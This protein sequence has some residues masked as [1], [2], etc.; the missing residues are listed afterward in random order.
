MRGGVSTGAG[1]PAPLGAT[2]TTAGVNFALRSPSSTAA[3]IVVFDLEGG[4]RY[5]LELSRSAH[6]TGDVWHI[7]LTGLEPPCGYGW[8]LDGPFGDTDRFDPARLLLD[9]YAR[10]LGGSERWGRPPER[11]FS[12]VTR[13]S[14]P[15]GSRPRPAVEPAERVIY[16]LS[17]RGFSRHPSSGGSAPGT[18]AGLEERLPQIRALGVTTVELLPIAEWDE[19]DVA[20]ESPSGGPLR[21]LW[22]YSPLSFFAPKAGL[23][24]SDR[25]DQVAVELRRLVDALH[26]A[27]LEV[28]LDVVFNHTG[29]RRLRVEDPGVAFQGIDRPGFYRLDAGGDAVDVTG[30]GNSVRTSHAPVADLIVEALRWWHR[31]IGVDGFRFDLAA[32]L[33]RGEDGEHDPSAPLLLR[34]AGDAELSAAVLIAEPW[35]AAGLYLPGRIAA[36]GRW[37]EWND[38]FRDT[39]RRFVRGDAG[40]TRALADALSGSPDRFGESGSP[41]ASINFVTCHDGFTLADLVTYEQR[42][43]VANGEGNRDG[44]R[45]SNGWNCGVEG[46]TEDPTVGSLRRRQIRNLLTLL[47]VARGVPM[48]LAGDEIGNGQ[49]GNNN[50][51]CQDNETG[52]VDWSDSDEDLRRFVAELIALRRAHPSLRRDRFLPRPED[53]TG[54]WRGQIE[55][56]DWSPDARVLALHWPMGSDPP[57]DDLFL[58]VNGSDQP[59][60]IEVPTPRTGSGWRRVVDTAATP[61]GDIYRSGHEPPI[62]GRSLVLDPR[63][64]ALLRASS[65]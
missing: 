13:S 29:E 56:P 19:L 64:I 9:P 47:L 33:A 1:A 32:A 61:P 53:E 55:T 40:E 6:R 25:A 42:H 39:V 4:E 37:A 34:I 45:W 17:V 52:W 63:S 57:D 31:D 43:N 48:L 24:V 10:A 8:R 62:D 59:V 38:R 26:D 44:S 35:D 15:F 21:N 3:S 65:P 28:L 20:F 23:A 54:C 36:G 14:V 18:F 30:C 22:G 27:G 60:E 51:Y 50:A 58:A 7:E 5:S 46:P 41:L 2:V 11:R 49:G 12:I 16:E